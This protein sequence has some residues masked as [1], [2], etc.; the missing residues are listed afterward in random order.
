MHDNRLDIVLPCYQPQPGWDDTIVQT[1]ATLQT[2]LPGVRMR[3]IIVNDGS[4]RGVS[5]A[6]VDRIRAAVPELVFVH[7]TEN[8]GKGYT[9]REGMALADAPVCMFTDIDFPYTPESIVEV[10]RM[11][12]VEQADIAPGIKDQAYYNNLPPVRVYVS[13][14]LRFLISAF[15]RLSV[16]DTQCGLKA[17]SPAGRAV[18]LRTTIN[19]YLA[20]LEC[21]FLAEHTPG[22]TIRPVA[23]HLKPGVVFSKLNPQILLTEGRNFL[24]VWANAT[25]GRKP[26][27]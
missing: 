21:L 8:K 3:L 4:A 10:Y 11:V 25:F 6:Q 14:F 22:I 12:A 7:R 20:D 13:R 24:K 16:T 1:W 18:F 2:L 15:L 9:V 5:P 23:V 26:S 27:A 19:R 17:F